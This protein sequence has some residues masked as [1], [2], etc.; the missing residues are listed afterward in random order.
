MQRE[1][2]EQTAVVDYCR[3]ANIPVYHVPNGGRRNAKE[4]YFLK[5]S[6]VSAGV[7]DLCIPLARGGFFG[8][9]IE[10]KYGKNKTTPA[11]D[12]WLELL[13]K[14]NYRCWIC[15]SADEAI[16]VIKSY[17]KL[18]PTCEYFADTPEE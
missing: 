5:R 3:Y 9:Y 14:E 7:P 10:M 4:A 17:V 13:H 8:L 15:Y 2:I 12:K 16:E 18:T 1:E 11:Q 6:G